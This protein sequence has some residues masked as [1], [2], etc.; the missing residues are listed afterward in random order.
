MPRSIHAGA[1]QQFI[2]SV[3]GTPQDMAVAAPL[4]TCESV[5]YDFTAGD[6]LKAGPW[7]TELLMIDTWH[8]YRQLVR[9]LPRWAP[10]VMRYIVLHDTDSFGVVD[11]DENGHGG[12]PVEEADFAGVP[13]K[14]GLFTAVEDFLSSPAGAKWRISKRLRNNSGLTVLER[15]AKE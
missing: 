12:V 6:D 4:A 14:V 11:E 8:V 3:Y 5:A 1:F 9:E 7:P 2:N 10:G 15:T 13:A